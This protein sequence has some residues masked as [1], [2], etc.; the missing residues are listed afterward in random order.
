SERIG[1]ARSLFPR[2]LLPARVSEICRPGLPR[3]T[4]SRHRSKNLSAVS[5]RRRSNQAHPRAL[6]RSISVEATTLRIRMETS[7]YRGPDRRAAGI[8]VWWLIGALILPA[9]FAGSLYADIPWPEV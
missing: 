7:P 8:C 6:P 3:G 9:G 1:I 5:N 2:E 4:A